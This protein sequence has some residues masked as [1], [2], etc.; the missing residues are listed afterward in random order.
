[1]R[2]ALLVLDAEQR[3]VLVNHAF[4]AR[5]GL[6]QQECRGQWLFELADGAW[7]RPELRRLLTTRLPEAGYVADHPVALGAEP[8]L[9]NARRVPEGAFGEVIL[10][11]TDAEDKPRRKPAGT[12]LEAQRMESVGTLADGMAHDINNILGP[13]LIATD[14]LRRQVT[15]PSVLR[16]LDTIEKSARRGADIVKQVLAFARGTDGDR[17]ALH[18]DRILRDAINFAQET[19]PRTIQV[20]HHLPKEL[21]PIEGDPGELHQALLKLLIN[22]REAMDD[23]GKL[24]LDARN[25]RLPSEEHAATLPAG[26]YVCIRLSDTGSG[27]ADDILGQIFDPFFTTKVRGQGTG[28]GLSTVLT[29]VKSH[30]GAITVDTAPGVGT[31]FN[32]YLPALHTP[33]PTQVQEAPAAYTK[34]PE[35]RSPSPEP[36]APEGTCILVVDDEPMVLEMTTDLLEAQGYRVLQ[37]HHGGEGVSLYAERRF[38]IDAVVTDMNM[39]VMTGPSMIRALRAMNPDVK[40]LAVSGL[41]SGEKDPALDDVRFLAKPF[42]PDDLL[43]ALHD[44]LDDLATARP[45]P[46]SP[47]PPQAAPQAAPTNEPPSVLSFLQTSMPPPAI[48]RDDSN[49]PPLPLADEA[50][51]DEESFEDFFGDTFNWNSL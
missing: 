28:L 10:V 11:I 34:A 3:V 18:P 42:E 17:L 33:T 47:P 45:R 20:S 26:P 14:M 38:D 41:P 5:F 21:W 13:I 22:A 40:I 6:T 36:T 29:I 50:P 25:A 4:T 9:V 32:L 7:D 19:F 48:S 8:L 24:H 2:E 46:A 44:L 16:R 39:P 43:G 23:V 49:F 15:D 27:I 37:A 51:A 1:M 12:T 30:G 35:G 31:T